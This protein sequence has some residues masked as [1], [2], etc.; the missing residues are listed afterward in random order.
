MV[1]LEHPD[2]VS[3]ALTRLIGRVAAE[4]PARAAG[5]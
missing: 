2:E 3:A 4:R 1:L 5:R